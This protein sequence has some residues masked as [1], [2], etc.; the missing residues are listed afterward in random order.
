MIGDILKDIDRDTVNFAPNYDDSLKE[1][2][3][4]PT[5]FPNLLVNGATGISAGYA[6]NIPPHNLGEIVDATIKR[7]ENSNCTLEDLME[8]V[9][10][11]DFPTGGIVSDKAGIYECFKTGRG[12]VVIRELVSAK[13]SAA[14]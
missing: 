10:G 12:K 4:L 5:K 7:I 11:P 2:T 8:I 13:I 9:K 3:V 6:T 1:P 14:L